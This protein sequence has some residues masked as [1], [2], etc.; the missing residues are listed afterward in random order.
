VATVRTALLVS[1]E[2]DWPLSLAVAWAA[3]GET[4]TAV[5]MDTAVGSARG[6]HASAEAVRSALEAGVTLAVEEGALRRRGIEAARLLEGVKVLDLDEVADLLV[7]GS[8][9]AVWL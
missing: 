7:D 5:L 9:R 3:A 2:V 1:G 6:A 4:V 8:T